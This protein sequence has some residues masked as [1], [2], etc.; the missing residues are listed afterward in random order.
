MKL[1]V[2]APTRGGGKMGTGI[3]ALVAGL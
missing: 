3:G 2:D 1:R